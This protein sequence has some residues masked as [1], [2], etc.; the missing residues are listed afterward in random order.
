M[1]QQSVSPDTSTVLQVHVQDRC[2]GIPLSKA[3]A[4]ANNQGFPRFLGDNGD[5]A[6]IRTVT[7]PR[8]LYMATLY[9]STDSGYSGNMDILRSM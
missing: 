2:G 9:N 1:A 4:V 7:V 5:Y 6:S 8:Y 3:P